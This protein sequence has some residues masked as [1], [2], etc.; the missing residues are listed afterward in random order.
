MLPTYLL[1]RLGRPSAKAKSVLVQQTF[2]FGGGGSGLS[3]EA[4]KQLGP[5]FSFEYM[6]AA[7]YEFGALPKALFKLTEAH[8]IVSF[9]FVVP[10]A[11]IA[12]HWLRESRHRQ[13]R[14]KEI[15]AAHLRLEKV[16][17]AKPP[18]WNIPDATFGVICREPHRA[19][20]EDRIRAL[21]ARKLRVRDSTH[22]DLVL[23]PQ[24]PRDK[25]TC[26]WIELNNGYLFF[27]DLEV[28]ERSSEYFLAFNE[29]ESDGTATE[30]SSAGL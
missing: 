15:Q 20:V 9:S 28:W 23:D 18:K 8:D 11:K 13:E 5:L 22:L 21:A 3:E 17:R 14:A 27:L 24:E 29:R 10:G 12:P 4:W 30:A 2:C 16:A 6:G 7:E 25:E 19:E 1:Q 26:G